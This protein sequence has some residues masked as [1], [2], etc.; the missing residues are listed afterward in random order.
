MKIFITFDLIQIAIFSLWVMFGVLALL[1]K[2]SSNYYWQMFKPAPMIHK[3]GCVLFFAVCGAFWWKQII[4]M[5]M[6]NG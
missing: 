4:E 1:A 3:I 5:E 6:E 2:L